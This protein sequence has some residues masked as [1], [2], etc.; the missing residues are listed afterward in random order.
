[1]KISFL[2]KIFYLFCTAFLVAYSLYPN[3]KFPLPPEDSLQSAEQAD[4]EI[5]TRR[6]YFTDFGREE[7]IAL[8]KSQFS[9][10]PTLRLN[11]PPE[12][13]QTL[14][15]DQTR[16]AYLEELVHPFRESIFINGFVP[17]EAKDEIWYRGVHFEEKITIRYY[18]SNPVVRT[19]VLLVTMAL[20]WFLLKEVISEKNTLLSLARQTLKWK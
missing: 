13:A 3:A 11:Y 18:S 8:Y 20:L 16:S 10:L 9:Y 15:R 17:K 1:M 6:A 4:T 5:S 12:D 7:V 14:I 19:A 2:I